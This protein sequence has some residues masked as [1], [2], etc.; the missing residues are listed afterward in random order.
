MFEERPLSSAVVTTRAEHA[1][2]ALVLDCRSDFETLPPAQAEDLGL[3]V[4]SLDPT[5]HPESWL[6]ADAPAVLERYAGERFTIGAPGDGSVV[7]T[8]QTD[9]PVVLVKPRVEGSPEPFIDFLIAEALVE[10]GLDATVPETDDPVPEHFLGF[11]ADQY[12]AFDDAVPLGPNA[13]YQLA[14]ALYD[15]WLGSHTRSV[16]ETWPETRP[17]LGAAWRDAGVRIE[18]R[19]DDLTDAVAS[20]DLDLPEATELACNAIKHEIDLPTPFGA[21]D[22]TAYRDRGAP[23]AVAWGQKTFDALLDQ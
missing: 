15:G 14:A 9:P 10:L 8:R 13:T 4:D 5:T 12:P 22:T 7:W 17:E 23:Y 16:F 11:F 6:P 2:D 3:L 20:G 21:L 19:I 1:P 18:P